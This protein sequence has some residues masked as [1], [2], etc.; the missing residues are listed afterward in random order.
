MYKR[1]FF[2]PFFLRKT[3]IHHAC[4]VEHFIDWI[5]YKKIRCSQSFLPP[6]IQFWFKYNVQ[7]MNLIF[8]LVNIIFFVSY[9]LFVDIKFLFPD[10]LEHQLSQHQQVNMMRIQIKLIDAL[11]PDLYHPSRSNPKNQQSIK[12]QNL[13]INQKLTGKENFCQKPYN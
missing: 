10:R 9:L 12:I 8:N 4:M 7:N 11:H 13:K 3:Y 6:F 1:R 2:D 5:T